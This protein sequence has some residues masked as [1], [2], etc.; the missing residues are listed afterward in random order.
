MRHIVP[1][2]PRICQLIA[3]VGEE[4]DRKAA[5]AQLDA[6]VARGLIKEDEVR[7]GMASVRAIV[8]DLRARGLI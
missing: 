7:K 4:E 5:L 1:Y 2:D 3:V 8:D 6:L